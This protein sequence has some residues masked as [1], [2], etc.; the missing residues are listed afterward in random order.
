MNKTAITTES[1][2]RYLNNFR[3]DELRNEPARLLCDYLVYELELD[4]RLKVSSVL[5]GWL[6]S[7]D[8]D[9]LGDSGEL[10]GV[11]ITEGVDKD[12][13]EYGYGEDFTWLTAANLLKLADEADSTGNPNPAPDWYE[14]SWKGITLGLAEALIQDM[15]CSEAMAT[16]AAQGVSVHIEEGVPEFKVG[17]R[18]FEDPKAALL[19]LVEN[20]SATR[21]AEVLR[22]A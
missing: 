19:E 7:T 2:A 6:D 12:I 15:N 14:A 11:S 21:R 16:L 1:L 10:G 20:L 9:R 13:V 3:R 22:R 8:L 18:W 5:A 17:F 4:N